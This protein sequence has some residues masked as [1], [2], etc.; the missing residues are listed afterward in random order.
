MLRRRL[1]AHPSVLP[2]RQLHSHLHS[3][4]Q[5]HLQPHRQARFM[6]APDFPRLR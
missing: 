1:D 6:K 4:L 3:H 2:S 5:S